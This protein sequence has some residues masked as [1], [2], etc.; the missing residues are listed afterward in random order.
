[1][2]SI[3]D[4][5]TAN[6]FSIFPDASVAFFKKNSRKSPIQPE[7][8]VTQSNVTRIGAHSGFCLKLDAQQSI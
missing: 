1:M 7:F 6:C 3:W 5:R 8:I 2:F 4:S